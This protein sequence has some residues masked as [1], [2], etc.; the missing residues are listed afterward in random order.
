MSRRDDLE[1]TLIEGGEWNVAQLAVYA[2]EL[3]AQGDPRGELIALDLHAA[4]HGAPTELVERRRALLDG[5]LGDRATDPAIRC[6]YGHVDLELD[7]DADRD[8]I[9]K[10]G[11]LGRYLRHVRISGNARVIAGAIDALTIAPRPWLTSLAIRQHGAGPSPI[12]SSKS[13]AALATAAP[14]LHTLDVHGEAVFASFAHPALRILRIAGIDAMRSLTN[15]APLLPGVV[16]LDLRIALDVTVLPAHD[17]AAWSRYLPPRQLPALRRLDLGRNEP[18]EHSV[19]RPDADPFR[20]VRLAPIAAQLTHLRLPTLRAPGDAANA[21]AALDRMPGLTVL[22]LPRAS[23]AAGLR[24]PGATIR[25]LPRRPWRPLDRTLATFVIDETPIRVLLA[26][27]VAWLEDHYDRMPEPARTA[28]D[29]LWDVLLRQSRGP[30]QLARGVRRAP[31]TRAVG[32]RRPRV[33]RS[34][35]GHRCAPARPRRHDP[36]GLDIDEA[37]S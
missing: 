26:D 19:R 36:P 20:F 5:L 35:S 29:Y 28:W 22:E 33:A 31:R 24:H 30:R 14:R 16:E 1:A 8:T 13:A 15:T 9:A 27:A 25:V 12:V 2:D 6:R 18:A 10:L 34:P 21:Q 11:S 17:D 3:Q 32:V 7:G 4:A 23:A 37:G